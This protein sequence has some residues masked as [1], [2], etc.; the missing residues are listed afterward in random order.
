MAQDKLTEAHAL[1]K[2][3]MEIVKDDEQTRLS[4]IVCLAYI[5]LEDRADRQE[6]ALLRIK[7][8]AEAYP[9]KTFKPV[10]IEDLRHADFAL[11][12][13]GI[14]MGALHAAWA[15]H[16]LNG[17]SEICNDAMKEEQDNG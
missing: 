13:I 10:T 1:L 11:R 15:R 14:D 4:Q 3:T 6:E 16:I 9:T 2:T 17:I 5:A 7:Q 12:A 8:W